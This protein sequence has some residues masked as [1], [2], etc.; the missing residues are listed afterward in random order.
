[1][2]MVCESVA[3]CWRVCWQVPHISDQRNEVFLFIPHVGLVLW[4]NLISKI[5]CICH[6][7]MY[8][9]DPW[10]EII[11]I[12]TFQNR[13]FDHL[14]GR[15]S[16]WVERVWRR[17]GEDRYL[18][19]FRHIE[20]KNPRA[21]FDVFCPLRWT[22]R[23]FQAGWM[24]LHHKRPHR[25]AQCLHIPFVSPFLSPF[26]WDTS[27]HYLPSWLEEHGPELFVDL[28]CFRIA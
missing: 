26:S 21:A 1:M 11:I 7:D 9:V 4:P 5:F 23:R 12:Q 27:P 6:C 14:K 28:D 8:Q 17:S 19:A 10:D 16:F 24:M 20:G 18:V 15:Q 3:D 25:S 13:F 22:F 2:M